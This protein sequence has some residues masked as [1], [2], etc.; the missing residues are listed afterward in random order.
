MFHAILVRNIKIFMRDTISLLFSFLTVVITIGL[1][2]LFLAQM[3]F[4]MIR[5]YAPYVVTDEAIIYLVNSWILA[6][7]LSIVSITSTSGAFGVVM[8][9][10]RT[11]RIIK[12]FKSS[13]LGKMKYPVSAMASASIVGFVMSLFSF[14]IYTIFIFAMTGYSFTIF[15]IIQMLGFLALVVISNAGILGFMVSCLSSTS[16]FSAVSTVISSL[17]G[18]A[19]GIFVPLGS[20]PDFM[21]TVVLLFPFMHTASIFR[22]ILTY[23]SAGLVFENASSGIREEYQIHF[24]TTLKFDGF[25]IETWMSILFICLCAFIFTLLFFINYHRKRKE[26]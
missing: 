9:Q 26:L 11:N 3:Q 24:G 25:L 22:N 19:T 2:I 1:Y 12:D 13:P 6:G 7:L 10:D 5:D 23:K 17:I 20:L 21:R 18:F 4:N 8:V 14:T 15:Q 16:A